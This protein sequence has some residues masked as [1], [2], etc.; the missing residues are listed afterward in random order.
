MLEGKVALVT[1]G[2]RGIGRQV[3]LRLATMGATVGINYVSNSSAAEQT[4]A[5]IEE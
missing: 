5:E 2:S 1:G 4:L 3:C